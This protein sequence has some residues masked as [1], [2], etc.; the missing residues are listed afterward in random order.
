M[1]KAGIS[2][3]IDDANGDGQKDIIVDNGV[4]RV[5]IEPARGGNITS[6]VYRRQEFAKRQGKRE[7]GLFKAL[8]L[9]YGWS[10]DFYNTPA[11]YRIVKQTNDQFVIEF[12]QSGEAGS[13]KFLKLTRTYTINADESI[14]IADFKLH[15]Q[16]RAQESLNVGFWL[17]NFI[18]A[19]NADLAFFQPTANGVVK[20]KADS[21]SGGRWN[22][23]PSRGWS[24]VVNQN[25]KLG[26]V[27]LADPKYLE[28]GLIWLFG[29]K[30]R[31]SEELQSFKMPIKEGTSFSTRYI[32]IP[33]NGLER[34]DGAGNGLAG[35][36]DEGK[37][38]IYSS[39][40][41][42]LKLRIY[43]CDPDKPD[44]VY[45]RLP[46]ISLKVCAD[47]LSS[48]DISP[49]A[50][51]DGLIVCEVLKNGEMT[52]RIERR[53]GKNNR[54]PYHMRRLVKPYVPP[55]GKLYVPGLCG[56]FITPHK[57]WAKPLADGK[58]PVCF[59]MPTTIQ[60]QIIEMAQRFDIE[61]FRVPMGARKPFDYWITYGIPSGRSVLSKQ[62]GTKLAITMLKQNFPVIV[63]GGNYSVR[64]KKS[65]HKWSD[66]PQ[67]VRKAVL[68]KVKNG[69]GLVII[70]PAGLDKEAE[71]AF[72]GGERIDH[73]HELLSWITPG[74]LRAREQ[75][76]IYVKKYGKGRVVVVNID[77]NGLLPHKSCHFKPEP[78]RLTDYYYALVARMALWA[79]GRKTASRFIKPVKKLDLAAIKVVNAPPGAYV[80]WRLLDKYGEIVDSG[81]SDI[82]NG[83]TALAIKMPT[84]G[85]T[86]Y[87]EQFLC[88][89]G[90]TF[91]WRVDSLGVKADCQ[92][93][94]AEIITGS[95]PELS[96]RVSWPKTVPL[97]ARVKIYSGDGDLYYDSEH[98]LVGGASRIPL[99]V[100]ALPTIG[101]RVRLELFKGEELMDVRE[102]SLNLTRLAALRRKRFFAAVMG[103]FYLN[104]YDS[105]LAGNRLLR[106]MGFDVSVGSFSSF[107]AR[108]FASVQTLNEADLCVQLENIRYFGIRDPQLI[109]KYQQT[110]D[111]K[112]LWRKPCL[113][114]ESTQLQIASRFDAALK[115]KDRFA[116]TKFSFGDEMSYTYE[117]GKRGLDICFSPET[118]QGFRRW[119]KGQ[120]GGLDKLNREWGS[121]F[122]NWN[123]V[124]PMTFDEIKGR[125]KFGPWLDHRLFS[126]YL[127]CIKTLKRHSDRVCKI[128][129]GTLIGEGGIHTIPGAYGGYNWPLKLQSYNHIMPYDY[130]EIVTQLAP[131]FPGFK[132]S[133]KW[134]GYNQAVVGQHYDAWKSL[135]MG[136]NSLYYFRQFF[137]L[138]GDYTLSEHGKQTGKLLK[139][140]KSGIADLLVS[141]KRKV[142]KLGILYSQPSVVGCY[143]LKGRGCDT[144][145]LYQQN[146][147]SWIN[148]AFN[149]GYQPVLLTEQMLP[150]ADVK[151][152]ILPVTVAI[153]DKGAESINRFTAAGGLLVADIIPGIMSEHGRLLKQGR[154]DKLFGV[155]RMADSSIS[156]KKIAVKVNSK[157]LALSD[158]ELTGRIVE[159]G[160]KASGAKAE[161]F[162][163][164]KATRIGRLSFSRGKSSKN[165]SFYVNK[166][167]KG[168]TIYLGFV[169]DSM[170]YHE[171]KNLLVDL[172][173]VSGVKP[174]VEVF[175]AKKTK[176]TRKQGIFVSRFEHGPSLLI[177]LIESPEHIENANTD[178]LKVAELAK[179]KQLLSLKFKDKYHVYDLRRKK[180]LGVGRQLD[181]EFVVGTGNLFAAVPFRIGDVS[182]DK[183]EVIAV[184]GSRIRVS[185]RIMDSPGFKSFVYLDFNTGDPDRDLSLSG[186]TKVEDGRFSRYLTTPLNSSGKWLVKVREVI[187]NKQINCTIIF[188]QKD[189]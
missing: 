102:L 105:A 132:Y 115:L 5:V 24:A 11:A 81:R 72:L 161:G 181:C 145:E 34:V 117:N 45:K 169:P 51:M 109:Y 126:D 95:S 108:D 122:E 136:A 125:D 69:C 171:N 123:Q 2:S 33:F 130:M 48:V 80:K 110:K 96:V 174:D 76:G 62:D 4:F 70:N 22:R 53:I 141:G 57:V 185:G 50:D 143:A 7:D 167:G 29:R 63:M 142:D 18:L 118:L 111:K 85:G 23:N 97:K 59:L 6:L 114:A 84:A 121:A 77:S 86:Y 37:I 112:Y 61:Y 155:T 90:K 74:I 179:Y 52:A 152:L 120:Y 89:D 140:L 172:L 159:T 107:M 12:K 158:V 119:L 36:V 98:R 116:I 184:P 178:K 56:K 139:E 173:Q 134:L 44:K 73:R 168:K 46:D 87:L 156:P 31:A 170:K 153:S 10:S 54:K 19:P 25:N 106:R 88:A 40:N 30:D 83:V 82:A 101:N 177:G 17:H 100:A 26:C 148:M 9:P 135:F 13:Q 162:A 146:I 39:I 103:D 157:L 16:K 41:Q 67:T 175:D 149:A 68:N 28:N 20:I 15:N 3:R 66:Y 79:S 164:S 71:K 93:E 92:I 137:L 186:L 64:Y 38:T 147:I 55:E 75:G 165:H 163:K 183:A 182:L 154:L 1:L 128:M 124:E 42:K 47:K 60:R 32:C 8:I 78:S 138:D 49:I 58:L 104:G 187:S 127:Y 91:D 131:N 99:D 35:K 113:S 150:A 129:P 176:T 94:D 65:F 188:K 180:Y 160:L 14:I 189:R 166:A 151:V 144:Y 133:T 27:F 21:G 43:R